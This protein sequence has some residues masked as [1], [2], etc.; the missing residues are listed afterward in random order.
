MIAAV[1]GW[2]AAL[3]ALLFFLPPVAIAAEDATGAARELARKTAAFAGRGEPV[4]VAWRNVSSLGSSE[5]TQARSAFEGALR[6]AGIRVTDIAPIAEARLTLSENRLQY[7]LVEDIRK[8]EERQVWI[9][10]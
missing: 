3:S 8:S 4:A 5:L 2:P 9:A 7:L 10:S 6:E 1:K